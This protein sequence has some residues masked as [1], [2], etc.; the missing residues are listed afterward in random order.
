VG[1]T[2]TVKVAAP[3]VTLPTLSVTVTVNSEPLSAPV[4]AG[5]V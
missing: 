2:F 5:V 1:G 4:V 3:L